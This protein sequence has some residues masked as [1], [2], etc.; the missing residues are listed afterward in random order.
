MGLLRLPHWAQTTR[1]K[2]LPSAVV[3]VLGE[4]PAMAHLVVVEQVK[5][6]LPLFLLVF[7]V[8]A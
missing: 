5:L 4:Q 1:L 8:T 6:L 2:Y 7:R 3:V